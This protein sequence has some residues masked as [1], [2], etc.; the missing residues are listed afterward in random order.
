M[1]KLLLRLFTTI[2]VFSMLVLPSTS[3]QA[4]EV[5]QFD[6]DNW[7]KDAKIA[8]D[9]YISILEEKKDDPSVSQLYTCADLIYRGSIGE[10]KL[11]TGSVSGGT[12]EEWDSFSA[13]EILGYKSTYLNFVTLMGSSNDYYNDNLKSGE[14]IKK[15][16][17]RSTMGFSEYWGESGDQIFNAYLEFAEYQLQYFEYYGFPYN[18]YNNKSYA[19]E[20]GLDITA[21]PTTTEETE[22]LESLGLAEDE[23]AEIESEINNENANSTDPNSINPLVIIIPIALILAIVGYVI[24]RKKNN[25]KDE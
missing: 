18:F 16:Y 23:I 11:Y 19:D 5:K 10:K 21:E 3:A 13:I 7:Y 22:N 4:Q 12:E 24:F 6:F 9:N 8:Y 15:S 1:K 2:T 17:F 25:K 20:T 14:D